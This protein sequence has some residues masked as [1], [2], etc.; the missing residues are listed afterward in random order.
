VSVVVVEV[1]V[2]VARP[3]GR[4]VLVPEEAP[5][6]RAARTA[7]TA[8]RVRTIA[9]AMITK[10]AVYAAEP[11]MPALREKLAISGANQWLAP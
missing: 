10:A 2:A 6:S 9:R 5:V 1:C 3:G 7:V 4:P 11:S 8:T